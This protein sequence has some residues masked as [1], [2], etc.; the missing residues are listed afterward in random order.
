MIVLTVAVLGILTEHAAST[1]LRASILKGIADAAEQMSDKLDRS[2]A[3][4][5]RDIRILSTLDVF[6]RPEGKEGERRLLL[7]TMQQA[8]PLYAWI[9]VADLSGHVT[10]STKG[11]LL[12]ADVSQR[13]WFIEGR[14]GMFLGDVHDAVLL[15]KVL[16]PTPT[17]EAL[18]FVDIAM[19]LRLPAGDLIGVAAVHLSW[20]WARDLETSLLT[21]KDRENGIELFIV[22]GAGDV[23]LAP[24]GYAGQRPEPPADLNASWPDGIRYVAATARSDGYRDFPGLGWR[25]IVRQPVAVA[26]APV[27]GLRT[28]ILIAGSLVTLIVLLASW[29]YASR[30]T[31]PLR[32][33]TEASHTIF[34]G[35]RS[36]RIPILDDYAEARVLSRALDELVQRNA[37]ELRKSEAL[38]ATLDERV[39]AR[40]AELAEANEALSAEI[41]ERRRAEEVR[42]ALIERL[43][44]LSITDSLTGIHNRRGFMQLAER[45]VQRSLRTHSGLWCI[46]LDI[47]HFKRVNDTYG[48]AAGDLV[49]R[50]VA[51][52][53]R[54]QL[55]EIDV[56]GRYGGEEF[57]IL[58][59]DTDATRADAVANRVRQAIEDLSIPTTKGTLRVTASFGTAPVDPQQPDIEDALRNADTAL[60]EAK[61]AGRNRVTAYG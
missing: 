41:E 21:P 26:L 57:V 56:L 33:L 27:E 43:A 46:M 61:S 47:D 17:Q 53:C 42:E 31:A 58:L 54:V 45:E 11:I 20:E 10:A 39:R 6:Q 29:A 48:H 24:P 12:G 36:A 40:T 52:C 8:Y 28:H 4:R 60:Y 49:L 18:R 44:A 9:G 3:Q 50:A 23:L 5:V 1:T 51:Q 55:R 7:D 22:D 32:R 59:A 14:N 37:D 38:A 13:P 2:M 16:P 34:S 19:P 25:V 30:I 35:D 15:A